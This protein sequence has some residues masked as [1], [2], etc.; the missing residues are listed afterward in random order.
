MFVYNIKVKLQGS[1]YHTSRFSYEFISFETQSM[2]LIHLPD[3]IV[4][5]EIIKS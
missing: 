1:M 5:I 3:R 4:V 2:K